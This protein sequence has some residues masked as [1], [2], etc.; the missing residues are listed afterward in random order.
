MPEHA[1]PQF[2]P[3]SLWHAADTPVVGANDAVRAVKH[4][5]LRL[6][7]HRVVELAVPLAAI[8]LVG[9]ALRHASTPAE[10]V[11]GAFVTLGVGFVWA[12]YLRAIGFERRSLAGPSPGFI[13]AALNRCRYERRLAIFTWVILILELAFLLPWWIEGIPNHRGQGFGKLYFLTVWL[14]LTL[15][16]ALALWSISLWRRASRETLQLRKAAAELRED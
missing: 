6:I 4:A 3:T 12:Y 9:L 7:L 16:V 11:L 5:H 15:M 14:P 13:S 10:R 2:D 8:T 1:P